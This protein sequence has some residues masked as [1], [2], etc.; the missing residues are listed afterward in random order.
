[1]PRDQAPSLR[2][3]V[4]AH[5]IAGMLGLAGAVTCAALFGC[6]NTLGE[7]ASIRDTCAQ[8]GGAPEALG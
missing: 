4:A 6:S 7:T 8:V 3:P 1:M 5:F 2:F